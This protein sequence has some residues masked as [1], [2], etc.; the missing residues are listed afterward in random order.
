MNRDLLIRAVQ[1]LVGCIVRGEKILRIDTQVGPSLC[2]ERAEYLQADAALVTD[3]TLGSF[4]DFV[5]E[6]WDAHDEDN[7]DAG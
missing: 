7:A 2:P 3:F 5:L 4:S 1:P 6:G